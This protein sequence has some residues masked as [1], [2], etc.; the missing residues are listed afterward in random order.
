MPQERIAGHSTHWRIW[1]RGGPRPVLALHCMLAHGGLWAGVAQGLQDVTLTAPDAPGHG[2]SGGWEGQGDYH[3]AATDIAI[4]MTLRLGQGGPV[5]LIGH[6]FGG[7]VA[8]RMAIERPDLARSL[9]LIEPVLFAAASGTTAMAQIAALDQKMAQLLPDAPGA[10]A[11]AFHG[12]WGTGDRLDD[13]P[14]PLRAYIIDRIGLLTLTTDVLAADAAGLLVPGR[15]EAVK[16][17]VL[18]LEGSN[19]PAVI[20]EIQKVLAARMPHRVRRVVQGAGHMLPLTHAPAVAT[21]IHQ[22]LARA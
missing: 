5:D 3:R 10:A 11:A 4:A 15:L 6:S 8:L 2:Q 21:A 19:S 12:H 7:T 22:H 20:P 13:L 18:L 14:A 1:D 17:P 9:V 16:C